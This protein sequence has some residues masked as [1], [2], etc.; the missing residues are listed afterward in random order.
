M[1]PTDK[2]LDRLMAEM[3]RNP[4]LAP[5][6]INV[7]PRN[8]RS[9]DFVKGLHDR[10]IGREDGTVERRAMLK[11]WLKYNS[12]Y[13]SDE[14]ARDAARVKDSNGY[15]TN[16]SDL[17]ALARV[18]WDR[19]NPIV[20]RLYADSS[21]RA[22]QT[23]ARWALYLRAIEANSPSDTERYR[24]ELKATVENK[25]LSD[26]VRDLALD[27]LSLE[28][29]WPG[30]DEWYMSLMQDE[31]LLELGTYTGLTT[32][33]SASPEDKYTDRM[34]ALL[35][36]E[37]INVR[38]AAA[39]NLLLRLS[40]DRP[41]VIKALLPWLS[42]P[43]WL[44]AG[45]AGRESLIQTLQ[46]V[47]IPEAV[48]AL[49][50]L[51]DERAP[52]MRSYP[53]NANANAAVSNAM[54]QAAMAVNAAARAAQAAANGENANFTSYSYGGTGDEHP[55]RY[56]AITALGFQADSRAVPALRR[57][58]GEM[59]QPYQLSAAVAAIYS[60]G[61]FSIAEQV[62]ALEEAARNADE[63]PIA[64]GS[65]ANAIANAANVV[66]NAV[67][68]VS[69]GY[70]VYGGEGPRRLDMD[71]LLG[72]HLTQITVVSDE[73]ARAVVDRIEAL[74]RT[75]A[76][77][78][79]VLRKI[80][81]TWDSPAV[82]ALHL[83][84]LKNNKADADAILRL[85]AVRHKLRE[86]LNSEIF[87]VRTG[88]QT[89]VG[90]SSCI[91]EDANDSEAIIEGSSDD[92][93]T[94]LLACAR[95]IRLPLP[96]E[97]VAAL[98]PSKDKLLAL[99]AE[100]YLESE[101]SP[102]ARKIVLSLH[103]NEA[104]ITGATMTFPGG[105]GPSGV[106]SPL[107]LQV[108]ATVSPFYSPI[109]AQYYPG[110]SNTST[111][112]DLERSVRDEVKKKPD[113]LGV[114][115]W[116]ENYIHIY[117][118]RAV[119]SWRDDPA[120][121]RERTL[122]ND[123]FDAFK[124]L[125]A[126]H[127]ADDLP[128]FLE[129]L[130]CEPRQL[131]MLGKN[132][133][134]RVYVQAT[135]LAPFFAELD[136]MFRDLRREPA[137]IKY[138]ASKGVPGLEV[139]FADDRLE[140]KAVWKNGSD[141][142]LLTADKVRRSEIDEELEAFAESSAENVSV[143][144]DDPSARDE[145][146]VGEPSPERSIEKETSR[147]L[148]ENFAWFE[149]R[150]GALGASVPQP[151]DVPYIPA[152]DDLS[153]PPLDTQWKA[154]VGTTEIRSDETGL[155]KVVAGKITKIRSGYYGGVVVTPNGRWA[156]TTKYDDDE[157]ARLVRVNLSTNRE[158]II[159]PEE[160]SEFR[161]IAYVSSISR[162]LLG[163]LETYGMYRSAGIGLKSDRSGGPFALLD[164]E[165]GKVSATNS[166]FRPLGQQTA[167]PLQSTSGPFEYWAALPDEKETVVGVY[168]ARTFVFKPMLTVPEISFDSMDM[169][170][171]ASDGKLYFVYQG[172]L[173]AAPFKTR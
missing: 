62:D 156:I 145:H 13:Y 53:S 30:R 139:L 131:L 121:Y 35:D 6:L 137:A 133:G 150:S 142:R 92:A 66:A 173:L 31:T 67:M 88:N 34:I 50:A 112:V 68:S 10:A 45:T 149:F 113:L 147:R 32:L 124:S 83:R 36:S 22:S 125:L 11:R 168:N 52:A 165:T 20:S 108:F 162:V 75:D 59:G 129:C 29:D 103:P 7:L 157:G 21:Q 93:R 71:R 154:T 47:K 110:F 140:A 161:P 167:R 81:V 106:S 39:R 91:L 97:K 18:D 146:R 58:F 56:M 130:Y 128:P 120:R 69:S 24:D 60:C 89:A 105:D 19:A 43:K 1:F 72:V 148:Y 171:D 102:A 55:F 73:L 26:G 170:V 48:P 172:H 77:T 2:V 23:A 44:K 8:S 90:I 134:R 5:D 86:T 119:L 16:H 163:P 151:A 152:T 166:D 85:L 115:N 136:Q 33:I 144:E 49:I 98:L 132:G 100:R 82:Y 160:F 15:L 127:R 123:E 25:S 164:P 76:K 74:D 27:A 37:N 4:D 104:K 153:V 64:F 17:I 122:T 95:L 118:D 46:R 87:N 101:D 114:Y 109:G 94:A 14:L 12:T 99:A 96:V 107:L 70:S 155:Y 80:V 40:A 158:T 51:L 111:I 169:W 78:S 38:S 61:G 41:D 135:T 9:A 84:D 159:E 28:K 143:D 117:K 3:E 116:Q 126:H 138:W 141:L 57:V 42:D 54:W 63:M 65:S 79:G